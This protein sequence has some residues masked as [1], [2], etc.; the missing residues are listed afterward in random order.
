M[1]QNVRTIHFNALPEPTRQRLIAAMNGTARPAPILSQ[2]ATGTGGAVFGWSLL[3]LVAAG[4]TFGFTMAGY[5]RPYSDMHHAPTYMV[6]YVLGLFTVAYSILAIVR[7]IKTSKALPYPQGRYLFPTDYVEAEGSQLKI[8]STAHL[9]DYRGV[10]HHYNGAYSYTALNFVFDG[11]GTKMF[12]V[13]GKHIAEQVFRDVQNSQYTLAEAARQRDLQRLGDLDVFFDARM[14]GQWDQLPAEI[15]AGMVLPQ[16]HAPYA[17]DTPKLLQRAAIVALLIG[18][19]AAVPTWFVRNYLSDEEAFDRLDQGPYVSR[20]SMDAYIRNHGNHADE[21]TNDLLPALQFREANA[22]GSVTALRDFIREFPRSRWAQQALVTIHQRYQTVQATFASQA[23]MDDPRMMPFMQRLLAYLE[24]SGSPTVDVRFQT[25][26]AAALERADAT[27]R[28]RGAQ[29]HLTNVAAVAGNF[30][31]ASAQPREQSITRMLQGAFGAVFPG[32]VMALRQG[33]RLGEVS[34]PPATIPT[35]EVAYSVDPSGEMYTL[36]RS[37]RSFVGISVNFVVTMRIPNDPNTF[38]ITFNVEPPQHFTVHYTRLTGA[39]GDLGH[40][41]DAEV[42]DQMA[43]RAFD[44]LSTRLRG[45]FFRPGTAGYSGT[46][47][48]TP[49]GT[50]STGYHSPYGTGSGSYGN[51]GRTY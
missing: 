11:V 29:M 8:V 33:E 41:A 49:T 51:R 16:S 5:G 17:K 2:K 28:E 7:K 13:H 50:G 1:Q 35:F 38:A 25:P 48:A 23:S 24:A 47:T 34:T 19:V 32:D 30:D 44:Q 37:R 18:T 14:G 3:A 42:Y 26:S 4:A 45:V 22:A 31:P 39:G 43:Q 46:T 6:G 12:T 27:I 9:R 15:P 20:Y 10:H 36:E 40:P 21:V